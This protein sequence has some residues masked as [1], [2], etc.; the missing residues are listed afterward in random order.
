[1]CRDGAQVRG[2]SRPAKKF[3][4]CSPRFAAGVREIDG[5]DSFL[6]SLLLLL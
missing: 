1:M 3:V 2:A 6:P 5:V 4:D